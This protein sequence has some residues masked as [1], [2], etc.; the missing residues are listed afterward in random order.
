MIRVFSL[1]IFKEKSHHND[2][3]R[4]NGFAFGLFLALPW[5]L[6]YYGE[7]SYADKPFEAMNWFQKIIHRSNVKFYKDYLINGDMF[8]RERIGIKVAVFQSPIVFKAKTVFYVRTL[9]HD[10]EEHET[11]YEKCC[12]K[13]VIFTK[14]GVKKVT[15]YA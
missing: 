9:E 15:H 5:K 8:G 2:E 4:F 3:F 13:T 7:S 1:N 12:S 14:N 6:I 11:Y 10:V